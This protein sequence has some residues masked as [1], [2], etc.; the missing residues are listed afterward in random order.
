MKGNRKPTF[1]VGR[2]A[3]QNGGMNDVNIGGNEHSFKNIPADS[4]Y[5]PGEQVLVC[6]INDDTPVIIG[7][8]GYMLG[9]P[10]EE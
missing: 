6:F 5:S 3:G 2:V 10:Q 4:F 1:A 8:P 9:S 7:K